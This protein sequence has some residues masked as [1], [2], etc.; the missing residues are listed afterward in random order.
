M[1]ACMYVCMKSMQ[2][3]S[4]LC[5]YIQPL[6]CSQQN[7]SKPWY[8]WSIAGPSGWTA[9][10]HRSDGQQHEP[11]WKQP[12]FAAD[13][14]SKKHARV[15]INFRVFYFGLVTNGISDKKGRRPKDQDFCNLSCSLYCLLH[16]R[17]QCARYLGWLFA[18]SVLL[19]R[20]VGV[21]IWRRAE[22]RQLMADMQVQCVSSYRTGNVSCFH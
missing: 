12:T 14:Y 7:D 22:Q 18:R 21:S 5:V 19:Y 11:K 20:Y 9:C 15:C 6:F 13:L 10:S 16:K 2:R 8:S 1:H 3:S 17:Q 4:A